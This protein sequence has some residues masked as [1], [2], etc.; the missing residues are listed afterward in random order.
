MAENIL[1]ITDALTPVSRQAVDRFRIGILPRTVQIK[2]KELRLDRDTLLTAVEVQSVLRQK[3]GKILPV[4]PDEDLADLRRADPDV[5]LLVLLPPK[6]LDSIVEHA[7]VSR[8]ILKGQRSIEVT[9]T[10]CSGYGLKVLVEAVA[11]FAASETNWEIISTFAERLQGEIRSALL[12][13]GRFQPPC[14]HCSEPR[15]LKSLFISLFGRTE[16]YL[17]KSSQQLVGMSK[18]H[19]EELGS[20]PSLELHIQYSR[21]SQ[22]LIKKFFSEHPGLLKNTQSLLLKPETLSQAK[23]VVLFHFVPTKERIRKLAEW[24]KHWGKIID[25]ETR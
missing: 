14:E 21:G 24:A 1:V 13:R 11:E 2:K 25:Q 23:K 4:D 9:Q 5:Q 16:L 18:D 20:D 15:G 10:S 8:G 17:V 7:V 22:K 3:K 12:V 19:F 6:S